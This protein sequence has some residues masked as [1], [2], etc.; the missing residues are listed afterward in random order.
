MLSQIHSILKSS[1]RDGPQARAGLEALYRGSREDFETAALALAQQAS[2]APA[3]NLLL[4]YLVHRG[5]LVRWLANPEFFTVAQA[6]KT[7]KLAMALE[8]G[9][10]LALAQALLGNT[11]GGDFDPERA[12][13]LVSRLTTE[14]RLTPIL[15]QLV[16]HP[17]PRVQSKA[18]L[19]VGRVTQ[20]P[21]WLDDSLR[22][23]DP[24]VRANSVEAYWG[25][26]AVEIRGL[27]HQ[28][29]G[30]EHHRVS[31][32]A[33]LGLYRS[34]DT[35]AISLIHSMLS[36]PAPDF[37]RTA[38]WVAGQ[39]NDPRF[40]EILS[41]ATSGYGPGQREAAEETIAALIS[42]R[43]ELRGRPGLRLDIL[44]S[45]EGLDGA[46]RLRMVCYSPSY[47]RW[48]SGSD[49]TALHW[50]VSQAGRR[51][52]RYQVEPVEPPANA[53]I[54]VVAPAGMSL[55]AG[56]GPAV[57]GRKRLWGV[58]HYDVSARGGEVP[59]PTGSLRQDRRNMQFTADL[60]ALAH[61]VGPVSGGAPMGQ[62]L[63]IALESVRGLRGSHH[64]AVVAGPGS[65]E[66]LTED[67]LQRVA[68]QSV[69]VHSI[70]TDGVAPGLARQ[71]IELA[72]RTGG[73]G[74]KVE[75]PEEVAAA[76][77][78]V[79]ES[80]QAAYEVSFR[81]EISGEGCSPG[82]VE[83]EVYSDHGYG[84]ARAVLESRQAAGSLT[85][86]GKE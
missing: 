49:L 17:N 48:L 25:S 80:S 66:V 24:R 12:L 55:V 20:S 86:A 57:M 59:A 34:G 18:A 60:A 56:S 10:D 36:H 3:Y 5:I 77:A 53:V 50:V 40:V 51:I 67:V 42:R 35:G 41:T 45:A 2:M 47:R 83:I 13:E 58:L 81:G 84:H 15:S 39:T 14:A 23:E 22:S 79:Y 38:V 4:S 52:D 9:F 76:V 7:A 32:N 64:L 44:R 29:A 65:P 31:G 69:P 43:D 26:G 74:Q 27:L 16:R 75:G 30:D 61:S 85:P 21:L 33:L 63:L 19:L 28:A 78:L 8:P 70:L 6:V 71:L 73:T 82:A 1:E 68:A 72:R 62:A 46:V 11:A 37:Q 54:G